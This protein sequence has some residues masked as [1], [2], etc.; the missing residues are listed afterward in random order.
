MIVPPKDNEIE[1]SIFGPGCG[2]CIII[3]AG[4]NEWIIVDS[5][6]MANSSSSVA[7]EYFK[8]LNITPNVKFICA[9]HWHD[10]HILGI[11]ELL[12]EYKDATFV[13]SSA[14]IQEKFTDMVMNSPAGRKLYK[15][16]SPGMSEMR[17]IYSE[18]KNRKRKATQAK[19]NTDI[20]RNKK[21]GF[22][23]R[24]IS[25]DDDVTKK[26]L[27]ALLALIEKN[28]SEN[29]SAVVIP[30]IRPNDISVALQASFSNTSILLGA[31]L[32]TK[33]WALS[34]KNEL[35]LKKSNLYK[36]AHHGGKSGDHDHIWSHALDESPISII[37]P[38]NKGS[39]IPNGTDLKRILNN[40]SQV[41]ITTRKNRKLEK[42]YE[43]KYVRK[44]LKEKK[45]FYLKNDYSYVCLRKEIDSNDDWSVSTYGNAGIVNLDN[46]EDFA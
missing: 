39:K 16:I 17:N 21:N 38:F 34:I 3:H 9:S 1:V 36:V 46:I 29:Q 41:Y 19:I 28:I 42:D 24:A 44:S 4:N 25:P 6:K 14:L 12:N 23:L 45:A 22:L 15:N 27:L 32:E 37:T 43:D 5:C 33:G 13:L 31:D 26:S 11:S 20:Y 35:N 40:S 7:L 10:D 30:N 18:L 8:S 2:E